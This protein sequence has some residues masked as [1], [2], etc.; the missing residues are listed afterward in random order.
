MPWAMEYP[1]LSGHVDMRF[2]IGPAG[3][4]EVWVQDHSDVPMG[5]QSCFGSAIYGA[6]WPRFEDE[7]EVVHPFLFDLEPVT[8]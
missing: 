4:G 2:D 3:L 6:D 8:P 1:E 7:A 5:V